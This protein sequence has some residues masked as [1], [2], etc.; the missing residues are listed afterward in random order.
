MVRYQY[1]EYSGNCEKNVRRP[2][3][4]LPFMKIDFSDR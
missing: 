3:Q 4:L 2:A 1:I